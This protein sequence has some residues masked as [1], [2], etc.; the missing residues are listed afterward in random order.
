MASTIEKCMKLF[1]YTLPFQISRTIGRAN[2]FEI[3]KS[4]LENDESGQTQPRYDIHRKDFKQIKDLV[5]VYREGSSLQVHF[6]YCRSE[7]LGRLK[8]EISEGLPTGFFSSDTFFTFGPTDIIKRTES[9]DGAEAVELVNVSMVQFR[10][11]TDN[12]VGDPSAL[13]HQLEQSKD[14]QFLR[15]QMQEIV[16]SEIKFTILF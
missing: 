7:Y 9:A 11:S 13:H 6:T 10:M 14:F 8:K 2:Y 16:G 1:D 12:F 4:F 5:Q 3:E 15:R